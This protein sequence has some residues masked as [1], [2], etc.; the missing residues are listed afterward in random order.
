MTL[1]GLARPTPSR[2]RHQ[3]VAMTLLLIAL[4]YLDRVCISTAAPTIAADLGLSHAQMGVV[5][6]AFTLS[7]ALFEVPS[8][9]MADRFG[10]RATLTR[11]VSWWSALT[12]A[13][14]L[15]TG[16]ASLVS[17]RLLFGMGEAGSFPATARVYERWLPRG[18]HASAFGLAIAVGVSGGAI[19][20][21]VAT[22]MLAHTSW[23]VTFA[24]FGAVGLVWVAAWRAVF[25]DDP[26]EHPRVNAAELALLPSAVEQAHGPVPWRALAR[27]PGLVALCVM[28]FAAIYGWYFYLTWLPTYLRQARGFDP[29]STGWLAALPYLAIAAGVGG[30][31]FATDRLVGRFGERARRWP[32]V[33]GLPLAAGAI[34]L[35]TFTPRGE[36]AAVALAAAAGLAALGVPAAWAACVAIGGRHAGVVSG[37]MNTCGNLGGALSPLVVGVCVDRLGS[38]RLPL[39]SLAFMYVVAAIAWLRVSP[40]ARAPEPAAAP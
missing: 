20:Q 24:L 16:M 15:A 33:V 28:Y 5:F 9:W 17:L 34:V 1:P 39:L 30:G 4:A 31:G 3:V 11:I 36:V 37:A 7:Y 13:T 21:P 8:G 40:E 32:G 6:S 35:A 26:R 2:V 10:P 19:T 18:R 29:A 38:W 25:R 12:A 22:W 14:G 27:S 23:R